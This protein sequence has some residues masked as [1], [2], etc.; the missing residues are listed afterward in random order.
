MIQVV[1]LNVGF[2][3]R[4]NL[5]RNDFARTAPCCKA[6]QDEKSVLLGKSLV[7]GSLVLEVVYALTHCR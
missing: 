2:Y 3:S 7:E 1:I 4:A 6:V 5:W